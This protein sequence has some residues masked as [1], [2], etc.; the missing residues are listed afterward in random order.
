MAISDRSYSYSNL[1]RDLSDM[2]STIIKAYPTFLSL[3][4]IG[5]PALAT[6][7]E[8]L[9]RQMTPTESAISAFDTDGDGTGITVA[10]TAGMRAGSIL[11]VRK[12]TGAS[13]TEQVQVT[14]VDSTTELTV[15]RDYG[16]TTGVT[17]VVGDILFIVSSPANEGSTGTAQDTGESTAAYNYT[18]IFERMASVSKTAQAVKIY[19]VEDALD[20][21]VEEQMLLLM[22]EMNNQAIYGRRV[23]RSASAQGT[24]GGILQYLASGNVTAVGGALTATAINGLLEDI[25]ED[26]GVSDNYAIVCAQNQARYISALNT[27]GSNP[28]VMKQSTDRSFGGYISSWVGDLPVQTG[29]MANIVVDPNFPKD[30]LAIVDMNRVKLVP[31]VDRS[32]TDEDATL[33]TYDGYSRRVLGEYTMEVKNGTTAHGLL[34]GLTL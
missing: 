33:A 18:Q 34:T 2:L 20:D 23:V 19:G 13:V 7:H 21:K 8:W 3:V 30:Q 15:V 4:E 32:L 12:A 17:L 6:K 28:T 27:A 1:K 9:E 24:M 26:G 22:R 31:L 25:F 5:A 14:T 10:S 29:F 16:S 11:G